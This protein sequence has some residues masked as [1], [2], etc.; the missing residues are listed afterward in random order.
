MALTFGSVQERPEYS[1]HGPPGLRKFFECGKYYDKRPNREPLGILEYKDNCKPFSDKHLKV[2]PILLQP[3]KNCGTKRK[4]DDQP[5]QDCNTDEAILPSERRLAY[6]C[7]GPTKPGKFDVNAAKALGL[8]PGPSARELKQGK[9]I[10]LENGTVIRPEQCVS[11]EIVGKRFLILDCPS[12]HFMDSIRTKLD[13]NVMNTN[14][15]PL[16]L[17]VHLIENRSI[18]ESEMYQSWLSGFGPD[19]QVT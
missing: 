13:P 9:S 3:E 1:L 5:A 17:I 6:I 18:F 2:Q 19:V 16:T 11:P 4:F 15:N 14:E 7:Q 12:L 10:V 8:T